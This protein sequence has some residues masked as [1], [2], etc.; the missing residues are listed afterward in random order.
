MVFT[1]FFNI[2][3]TSES[4]GNNNDDKKSSSKCVCNINID[5]NLQKSKLNVV[6][7]LGI[8]AWNNYTPQLINQRTNLKILKV[9][10]LGHD[11]SY[12]S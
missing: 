4:D 9:Q 2:T 12:F 6:L 11:N 8:K 7:R 1:I 10:N 5:K 3:H